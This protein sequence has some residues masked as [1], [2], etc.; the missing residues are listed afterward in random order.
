MSTRTR[1]PAL[2]LALLWLTTAGAS[3][4]DITLTTDQPIYDIGDIVHITAHNNGPNEEQ[5][6]SFPYFIIY[7]DDT[8]ECVFG[9]VGLPVV[10][11]FA[12]G[13]TVTMDYDTGIVPDI[14]GN[15]TV[16]IVVTNG[17]TVSYVL[18]GPVAAE[19]KSWSDLKALYR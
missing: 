10:T 5:F 16:G 18:N 1:I 2:L 15:Y 14:A 3:L 13:E 8:E 4:A 17:T 11:P 6:L 7:N 12:V 19:A 9:C